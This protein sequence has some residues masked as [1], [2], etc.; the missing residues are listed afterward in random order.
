[1]QVEN[2]PLLAAITKRA[3]DAART[4]K[5]GVFVPMTNVETETLTDLLDLPHIEVT[6]YG[7]ERDSK[8]DIVHLYG[9]IMLEVAICSCC[10]ELTSTIK[11]HK[12]RCV[13][14]CDVWGKRTFLHVDIRRFEC[15]ACGHRFT[16]ELQAVGWRR[17]Q[18][19]RF[20]QQVY[21][22][23]LETS[24]NQVAK[25]FYL[26]DSTVR[27]IFK[28]WAKQQHQG[29]RFGLVRVLGIDEISLKKRHK[30]FAVVIS[31]LERHCVLAVLP[32][33]KM[34]TLKQWVA[35]LSDAQRAAIRTVS[36]DMWGPYRHFCKQALPKARR[37]AD[38][39][40]VMQQLNKRLGNARLAYQ[41]A[42][43]PE[44]QA[45]LKGCRWL[46]VSV[47]DN[48]TPKQERK[49]MQALDA[50]PELKQIYLLKEEF[51]LIFERIHDQRQ[52]QRFLQA[53]ICKVLFN[54][55]KQL[56]AFVKTLL[57]WWSEIL[58]YFDKRVTSGF[59]EGI[60][61]AIRGLIWRAYGFRNF[62]NFRLQVLAEH[63]FS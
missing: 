21:Q 45:A 54:G 3:K 60:N 29:K 40:H 48:L 55:H 6:K 23:C 15:D 61:R 30:Q 22:A 13:R 28:R 12:A 44:T 16:E 5:Q 31:D 39:F 26:N 41:R 2:I 1:M 4:V 42:A 10:N 17:R 8:Q 25:K 62:D 37:V 19:K 63:G 56:L 33:R 20:E 35:N 11:E 49:L 50:A 24:K 36:M 32:D 58:N 7:I 59:V 18:T 57:N 27:G 53:W 52:A 38:R 46:F 14:D 43:D 51:R 9:R 47:R 34:E